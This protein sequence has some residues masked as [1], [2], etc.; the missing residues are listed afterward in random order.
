[1]IFKTE[2]REEQKIIATKIIIQNMFKT[3]PQG[4]GLSLT[5][6]NNGLN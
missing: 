6:S 3:R 5:K 2:K 1:M 4:F